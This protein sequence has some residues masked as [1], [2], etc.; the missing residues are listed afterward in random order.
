MKLPTLRPLS[1]FLSF[2]GAEIISACLTCLSSS[3]YH[4]I[5]TLKLKSLV[6]VSSRLLNKQNSL[7]VQPRL[8]DNKAKNTVTCNLAALLSPD[9]TFQILTNFI[10][11]HKVIVSNPLTYPPTLRKIQKRKPSGKKEKQRKK[12]SLVFRGGG[13]LHTHHYCR[14]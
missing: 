11:R 12:R 4:H 5:R 14:R 8:G 1:F 7:P 2:V 9:Q 13:A 6:I 10:S 3:L